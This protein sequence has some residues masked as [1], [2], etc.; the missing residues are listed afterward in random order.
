MNEMEVFLQ[1]INSMKKK[2]HSRF[3]GDYLQQWINT[4]LAVL[5]VHGGVARH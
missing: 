4:H 5:G 3:V 1:S 2:Y